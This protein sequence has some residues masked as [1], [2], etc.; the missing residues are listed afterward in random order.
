MRVRIPRQCPLQPL[1]GNPERQRTLSQKRTE[2]QICSGYGRVFSDSLPP[3]AAPEGWP[4]EDARPQESHASTG[5]P[6]P[7]ETGPLPS[8]QR[9]SS[10]FS[11]LQASGLA[12]VSSV[13]PP[14]AMLEA[15]P[16]PA[17]KY[18]FTDG[19]L[20]PGFLCFLPARCRP[21]PPA[22]SPALWLLLVYFWLKRKLSLGPEMSWKVHGSARGVSQPCA[23]VVCVLISTPGAPHLT[24]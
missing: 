7:L 1:L 3:K 16:A 11:E 20:V 18:F 17:E 22:S 2:G 19:E 10:A 24:G 21:Q 8:A 23:G 9:L 14:R 6:H 13:L 5:T 15:C 4:R 12:S